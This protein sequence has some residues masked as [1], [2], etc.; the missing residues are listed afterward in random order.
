MRRVVL[1]GLLVLHSA[2]RVP[3]QTIAKTPVPFT[4]TADGRACSGYL[5]VLPKRLVWKSSWSTCI[6]DSWRV[7]SSGDE[8]VLALD[9]VHKTGSC[10]DI[11]F[12]RIKPTMDA[13]DIWEVS[14]YPSMDALYQKKNVLDCTMQ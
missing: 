1:V 9:H 10:D 8:T 4:W 5:K 14:G 3:A 11:R 6:A 13:N 7:V 12:V 2:F